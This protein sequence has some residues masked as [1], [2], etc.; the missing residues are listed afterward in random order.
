MEALEGKQMAG[1]LCQRQG[2]CFDF[3][4]KAPNIKDPV[5]DLECECG[6]TML[7]ASLQS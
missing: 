4:T 1:C 5:E 6:T 3:T 7:L 2:S